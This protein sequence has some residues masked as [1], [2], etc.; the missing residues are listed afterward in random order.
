MCLIHI[1]PAGGPPPASDPA[2]HACPSGLVTE[3]DPDAP[4]RQ[5]KSLAHEN[6]QSQDKL[7]LHVFE[8]I[9]GGR[10]VDACQLCREAGQPW[11]AAS[12]AGGGE[13]GP[14]PVGEAT[15]QVGHFEGS[16]CTA[17]G[18]WCVANSQYLSPCITYT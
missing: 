7:I 5:Q 8:L 11:R 16:K 15:L 1:P 4:S 17:G 18:S 2:S 12:L 10:L 14:V 13:A 3:L 9:R 6:V